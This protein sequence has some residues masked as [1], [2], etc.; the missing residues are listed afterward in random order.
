M[1]KERM[2]RICERRKEFIERS[3]V[4]SRAMIQMNRNLLTQY[5][6]KWDGLQQQSTFKKL[7][8]I[9]DG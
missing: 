2:N 4:V 6:W 7:L 1:R 3:A 8:T 5:K 9:Q